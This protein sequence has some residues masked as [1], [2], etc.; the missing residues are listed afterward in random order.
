MEEANQLP[1]DNLIT[2]PDNYDAE[3]SVEEVGCWYEKYGFSVGIPNCYQNNNKSNV[4]HH[5]H[6]LNVVDA[7]EGLSIQTILMIG[8]G[9]IFILCIINC[10]LFKGHIVNT[11]TAPTTRRE[12]WPHV[13]FW[14]NVQNLLPTNI[15]YLQN[16][17]PANTSSD[18]I[19]CTTV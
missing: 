12:L 13:A 11:R 10:Q 6:T 5:D 16:I 9:A 1:E 19:L 2:L 18:H 4:H 17:S 15:R 14:E 8:A 7:R 3:N